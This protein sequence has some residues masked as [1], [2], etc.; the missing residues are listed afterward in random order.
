[1]YFLLSPSLDIIVFIFLDKY[2][3]AVRKNG[4]KIEKFRIKQKKNYPA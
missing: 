1:M 3:A 2:G 4:I